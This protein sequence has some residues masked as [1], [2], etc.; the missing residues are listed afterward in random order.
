MRLVA[1]LLAVLASWTAATAEAQTQK[2]DSPPDL[3]QYGRL[4]DGGNADAQLK[5]GIA[6]FKARNY[7]EAARYLKLAADQNVPEAQKRLGALNCQGW[8]IPK[9]VSECIRLYKLAAA[10]GDTQAEAA[11]GYRFILGDGIPANYDE[12]VRIGK[13]L[14]AK[15]NADGYVLLGMCN[16]FGAGV[17]KNLAEALR[18]YR[19]AAA[20]GHPAGKQSAERLSAK[21]TPTTPTVSVST[22][23]VPL[24]RMPNGLFLVPALLNEA[25]EAE[26]I[27]DSGASVIALPENAV[28]ALRNSGKLAESE[29]TGVQRIKVANGAVIQS[30]TF[31]LRSLSV[32]GRFLPNIQ[33]AVIPS[34][35]TPLL[36]QSFLAR[37]SSWSIDNDRHALVLR[38]KEV[39]Q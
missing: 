19:Q 23:T 11:I 21:T 10:G 13:S 26:F 38:E 32:N 5:V 1:L 30:K 2:Y 16:E 24:R 34:G 25:V 36:G 9:N 18:L 20:L 35:S 15:G 27:V 7:S 12:A 14:S 3:A 4:A 28:A 8:G 37:F 22:L 29:F 6:Y 17:P 39:T 31:T 33:A